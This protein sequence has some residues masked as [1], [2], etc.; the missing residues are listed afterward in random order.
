MVFRDDINF[1]KII[2]TNNIKRE[3]VTLQEREIGKSTLL[4]V[5]CLF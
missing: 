1:N 4:F 5:K 2:G 3:H